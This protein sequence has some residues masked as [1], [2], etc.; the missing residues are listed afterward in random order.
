MTDAVERKLRAALA[1]AEQAGDDAESVLLRLS[2][3]V[4]GGVSPTTPDQ[5]AT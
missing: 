1:L 3:L 2:R 5:G 4:S